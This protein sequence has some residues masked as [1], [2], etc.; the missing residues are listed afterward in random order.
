MI[1][2]HPRFLEAIHDKKKVSVRFYSKADSGVVDRTCAPLDY[3]PGGETEDDLNRYWFWDCATGTAAKVFGLV[4]EQIVE[5]S[6]L[7]EGFDPAQ[8]GVIPPRWS[9]P[10]EWGAPPPPATPPAGPIVL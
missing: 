4:A 1:P 7:G 9:V 6:V 10:R 5:L 3:G 8:L 2:N